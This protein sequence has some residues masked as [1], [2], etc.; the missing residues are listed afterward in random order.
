MHG[1]FYLIVYEL[2]NSSVCNAVCI[3]KDFLLPS[4]S[5]VALVMTLEEYGS[6][7]GFNRCVF[8]PYKQLL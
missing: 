7:Q 1:H 2:L 8:L 5:S 4:D 3:R 6:R